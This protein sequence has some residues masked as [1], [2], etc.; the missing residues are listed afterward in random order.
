MDIYKTSDLSA[1]VA[2]P[3][4]NS[5]L[6]LSEYD[7]LT[8]TFSSK[9]MD[10]SKLFNLSESREVRSVELQELTWTNVLSINWTA[11]TNKRLQEELYVYDDTEGCVSCSKIFLKSSGV[12][13]AGN[14]SFEI[15]VDTA[16]PDTATVAAVRVAACTGESKLYLQ[17]KP[18]NQKKVK[19]IRSYKDLYNPMNF[20]AGDLFMAQT[21]TELRKVTVS[22]MSSVT[23]GYKCIQSACLGEHETY[24]SLTNKV[25]LHLGHKLL[26]TA[27]TPYSYRVPIGCA[28]VSS[29][30]PYI[31]NHNYQGLAI[32][33][34]G[35]DNTNFY[36]SSPNYSAMS[37]SVNGQCTVKTPGSTSDFDEICLF[38]I[39]FT[40]V[41]K[42]AP[43]MIDPVITVKSS[44]KRKAG[45]FSILESANIVSAGHRG[46]MITLSPAWDAIASNWGLTG[47]YPF[48]GKQVVITGYADIIELT[49][50]SYPV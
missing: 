43:V 33:S 37:V 13:T 11:A 2:R 50:T 44:L 5:L 26:G 31:F 21:F 8:Q 20:V 16:S 23:N 24:A 32:F 41:L 48:D 34:E 30:T 46:W 25:G 14:T 39:A 35:L 45:K 40:R 1:S 12:Y 4:E 18:D 29:S 19:I 49:N 9:R 15:I 36:H 47:T 3:H 42:S 22:D 27:G 28:F 17:I 6:E 38:E 7:P 10:L